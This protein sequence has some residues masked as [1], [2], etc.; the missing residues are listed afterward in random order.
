[1]LRVTQRTMY[2]GFVNRMNSNLADYM[3]SNIQ[4]SSMKKINRPSDDPA[5][6]ARV[7]SYRSS[8]ER[9]GQ[10]ET[11]A[12]TAMGWLQLADYTLNTTVSTIIGSSIMPL[13]EQAASDPSMTADNR[14]QIARELRQ[15]FGSLINI[16]NT[17]YENKTIFA[18]QNYNESA[19]VEG[20]AV[21]TAGSG[22]G[23]NN[24]ETTTPNPPFQ[25]TGNLESTAIVSFPPPAGGT[26]GDMVKIEDGLE[27]QYT[28]D[29]VTW[30]TGQVV[31][32][33][34]NNSFTLSVDGA[35]LSL[36]AT[37]DR[38]HDDSGQPLIPGQDEGEQEIFVRTSDQTSTVLDE[39]GTLLYV[40]PAAIYQG[41]DNR[42]TPTISQYGTVGL[43]S[44]VLTSVTGNF[45]DNTLVK[46]EEGVDAAALNNGDQFRYQYSTDS[47]RTWTTGE[48]KIAIPGI[49]G[50]AAASARLTLPEGHMDVTWDNSLE[51]IPENAQLSIKPQRTDLSF[52]IMEGQTI[53][54]NNVGK[55]IFGGLYQEEYGKPLVAAYGEEDGRNLFETLGRLIA[56]CETND[57]DGIGEALADLRLA[58][59][60][61]LMHGTAIGGKENRISAT[62]QNLGDNKAAQTERMSALEDVDLTE[63]LVRLTQQQMAYQTTL[64]SSSMIM[65]MNLTQFV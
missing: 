14:L 17:R 13:A 12:D 49:T 62:L 51:K 55:D 38:T 22:W 9:I 48:A 64:Q 29:G 40:R 60:N 21:T 34:P 59:N 31:L 25:V 5:G 42:A 28:F 52:N 65:N 3:E 7:L 23:Q 50:T 32:D 35:T 43:P 37:L 53:T 46:F 11:S 39:N 56:C 44:E 41:T 36:P 45:T 8:I 6:M 47:G 4:G 63:L 15:H 61:V 20:L 24:G 10:L 16:A 19:F 58:H 18:G 1:M 33:G 27:Y 57:C 26:A 54:V 30:K 2:N